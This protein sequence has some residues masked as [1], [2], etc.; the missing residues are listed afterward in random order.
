MSDQEH[1]LHLTNSQEDYT[2]SLA[3]TLAAECTS[4]SPPVLN[5]LQP[6]QPQHLAEASPRSDPSHSDSE[7]TLIGKIYVP[8][9][10]F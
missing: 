1:T 7:W 8:F 4:S 2:T 5:Q 10:A 3:H 9:S 6:E